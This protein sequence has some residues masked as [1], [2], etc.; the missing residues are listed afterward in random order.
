MTSSHRYL[1]D[2]S[3][4]PFAVAA[5]AAAVIAQRTGAD[6]HDVALVL[7]SGWGQTAD[8]IGETLATVENA[9]VPGFHKAAVAGHSG[10]MRSVAIGD[11]GRRA[12]V[13]GTRTPRPS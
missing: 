2:P 1:S 7:G 12:L 10:S 6:H 8:L 13:F 11:T 5:D 9:D 3:T 4:D